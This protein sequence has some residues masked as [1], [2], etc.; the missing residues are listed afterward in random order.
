MRR[1]T[2]G[3]FSTFSL[4]L[5]PTGENFCLISLQSHC[6]S[7][8]TPVMII[9]TGSHGCFSPHR[10]RKS[11][12]GGRRLWEVFSPSPLTTKP[13]QTWLRR[14]KSLH[15]VT[16]LLLDPAQRPT[17]KSR[18]DDKVSLCPT[19]PKKDRQQVGAYIP[20]E[21]SSHPQEP[22]DPEQQLLPPD[23]DVQDI[24]ALAFLQ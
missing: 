20:G 9:E 22:S 12:V 19:K 2:L 16:S 14:N 18:Q 8:N 10:F 11:L 7:H 1:S 23:V 6:D 21:G 24:T 4:L 15:M 5:T 3:L 17:E 13:R